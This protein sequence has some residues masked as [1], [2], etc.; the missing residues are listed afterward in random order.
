MRTPML[1]LL[2]LGSC[3][4]LA[5]GLASQPRPPLVAAAREISRA[6]RRAAI[7]W[8]RTTRDNYLA[9]SALQGGVVRAAADGATQVWAHGVVSDPAHVAAIGSLGFVVSGLAGAC[10]LRL[11]ERIGPCGTEPADCV[12]KAGMDYTMWAPLANS[13]Y[14]LGV[15]L[16]TA[17]YSGGTADLGLALSTW[18]SGFLAVMAMELAIFA[19][20]NVCAFKMIPPNFRPQTAA[21]LSR[22]C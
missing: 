2:H 14:L 7:S 22:A 21:V 15:P 16:L 10:W 20:Y 3:L 13:A 1:L 11:L 9:V 17:V 18:E 12:K 8:E 5:P 6:G 19:P 4:A